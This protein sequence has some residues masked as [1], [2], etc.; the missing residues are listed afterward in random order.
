[1]MDKKKNVKQ[2]TKEFWALT[3]PRQESFL[4]ELY[5]LSP[6][7]KSLFQVRLAKN[8][9]LVMQTL[10]A[11]IEKQT[12]ARAGKF[13]KLRLAKINEILRNAKKYALNMHQMIEIKR[14]VA[15]G[16]IRFVL[17]HDYVSVPY[18]VAGA[19]HLDQYLHMVQIHILEQSEKEE[20][21]EKEKVLLFK[22]ISS[23]F[24][25]PEIE[26][27]YMKYFG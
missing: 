20:I 11:E 17:A 14:A 18:M 27:V 21:F 2:L 25:Y 15:F 1:M 7:N 9:Q 26:D 16:I 19:R 22:I 5:N 4:K 23:T 8:D 12:V 6:S 24:Y 10:L 13:R 3:R